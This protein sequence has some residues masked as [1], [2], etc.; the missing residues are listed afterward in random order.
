MYY[1]LF[2]YSSFYNEE[3]YFFLGPSISRIH[4]L[5]DYLIKA[6]AGVVAYDEPTECVL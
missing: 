3:G 2:Y 5:N 1:Y 6:V 4:C